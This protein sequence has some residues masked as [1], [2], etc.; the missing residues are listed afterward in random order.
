[1]GATENQLNY[2]KILSNYDYTKEEDERDISDFLK[3]RSKSEIDQLTK[4][5]ASDLIQLLL[6]RPTGYLL[7]C[8]IILVLDKREVNSFH[9]LSDIEACLHYCPEKLYIGDCQK[10]QEYQ[11]KI[12]EYGEEEPTESGPPSPNDFKDK[13]VIVIP[14]RELYEHQLTNRQR[15][16]K[17]VDDFVNSDETILSISKNEYRTEVTQHYFLYWIKQK[18]DI[19][20]FTL[21]IKKDHCHL[22]K[23]I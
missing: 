15:F 12:G 4:R 2:I 22:E 8:D 13:K 19:N 23:K 3:L 9:V 7:P 14:D 20:N 6:K 10:Y 18:H 1:M 16:E 5:E 11:A 21:Y 17:M